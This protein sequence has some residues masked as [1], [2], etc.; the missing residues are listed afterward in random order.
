M[1]FEY[2]VL[3][4]PPFSLLTKESEYKDYT[5]SSS[6]DSGELAVVPTKRRYSRKEVEK[7]L[8]TKFKK[9]YL[10]NDA[11]R[12]ASKGKPNSPVAGP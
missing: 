6:S 3:P 4:M 10:S 11:S 7:Q 9:T 12:K 1:P 2:I 8:I 5:G